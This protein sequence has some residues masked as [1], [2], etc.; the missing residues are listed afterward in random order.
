MPEMESEPEDAQTAIAQKQAQPK[1][2]S[3]MG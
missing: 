2:I 3:L 1:Q